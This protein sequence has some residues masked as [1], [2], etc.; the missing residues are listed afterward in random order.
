MLARTPGHRALAASVAAGFTQYAFAFV[1]GDAD[2]L[3]VTDARAAQRLRLRAARL[4]ARAHRH[5]MAALEHGQPGFAQ[6]LARGDSA[7]RLDPE[8]VA[9]AYWAAASWGGTIS[10]S[11]DRPDVVADLPQ[12][13]RLARLAWTS[14]PASA[15]VRWRP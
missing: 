7:L 1:A 9:V 3:E 5:A 11:K 2:R 13:L 14:I 4:Y 8:A 10:L 15:T 12:A 6:A